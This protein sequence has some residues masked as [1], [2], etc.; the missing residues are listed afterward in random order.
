MN[1]PNLF[2]SKMDAVRAV[3]IRE[4][5]R[6]DNIVVIVLELGTSRLQYFQW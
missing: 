2:R 1:V 6:I 4:D 3:R 5:D